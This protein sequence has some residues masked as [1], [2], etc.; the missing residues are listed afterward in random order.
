[1]LKHLKG[2]IGIGIYPLLPGDVCNFLAIDFDKKTYEKDV[3]AFWSICDELNVPIYVER[4]RS[5][6]GAHVWIFFEETILAKVARKLG[7]I[8]LTKTIEKGSLDLSSYD[9]LFP[10]QDTMPKGG[11]GNLIALPFQGE[12]CKEGNTVFVDKYFDVQKKQIEILANLKKMTKDEVYTIVEKYAN[13]D[14]A[15]PETTEIIEDDEIPKKE[16]IKDIIFAN[17]IECILDNQIYVKK[18]K[19]LPN[20]ISYLKR[21]AS[22][23][24][25]EFYE[26]QRLRL[27]IYKTP[28]IISCFEEDERFL[29]LPRGCMDKIRTICE[30]SNV[31]L[32]IKDNRE[33]GIKTDYNFVGTLNKK[34]EKVMNELLK[35]D[36]GV[37]CATTGF[38]KTVIAA[39]II[40]KLKVNALVLVN[41]NSLLEQWKERL[42][43]FLDIN[44]KEIGQIGASRENLNGKLDIASVQSLTKKENMEDLVKNY[45]LVI[46]DECHHVAAYGFEQVMKAIRSKYVYGLTATPTRKDGLHKII[47]MQC[48]DIRVRVANRELKQNRKMEHVVIV[49]NTGYK[50]IGEEEKQKLQIS[51]LLNDMC[52]NVFRNE[53][54][55]EDIKQSVL[56][57]RIPIVLTERVDH[58][59][60]LKEGLEEKLKGLGIPVVIYKGTM[61]KKQAVEVQNILREADEEGRPRIILATSSSIG[62]GFD[63]SRLDTLFLTMPV[64]WKG[65][66]IQYVGRLHR[67]HDGKNKVIVYDYLDNMKVL[68]KMFERRMRGYKIAGYEVEKET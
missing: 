33:L 21:L 9:R 2:E 30:K 10:N 67:E 46:V 29:I 22:F 5:G 16:N 26:K 23:T 63:D 49:K 41:R 31:K 27:P 42:S 25:P 38:G 13:E 68:D 51:E 4:S 17:N 19:L 50:F 58:L 57:G 61:G 39:K 7:N 48:G 47:Y 62:E 28:R 55:I 44:K 35:Y 20:E 37:L 32:V 45:G 53:I 43:Y 6:N 65:R 3:S 40:S 8:L 66:I 11:F 24:N 52:N 59:K 1:M 34:Q 36:T 54:I 18:L 64:S 60:I 15:E 14:F 12:S 56:Q